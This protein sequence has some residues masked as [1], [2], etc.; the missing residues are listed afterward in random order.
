[1]AT[2][3]I[4][5]DRGRVIDVTQ[6]VGITTSGVEGKEVIRYTYGDRGHETTV[7]IAEADQIRARMRELGLLDARAD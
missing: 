2:N 5:L 3:R 1:M 7:S 6:I 4:E